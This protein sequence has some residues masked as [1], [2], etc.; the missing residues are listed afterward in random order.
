MLMFS[1][2]AESQASLPHETS[3]I[4]TFNNG[5]AAW[6]NL[7]HSDFFYYIV[8]KIDLKYKVQVLQVSQP[9]GMF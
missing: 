6:E 9:Q 1:V 8:L 2:R 4:A 5:V 7:L 3:I